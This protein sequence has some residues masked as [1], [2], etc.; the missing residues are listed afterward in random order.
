M[1]LTPSQ[2]E[3][4]EDADAESRLMELGL[5]PPRSV[6][7]ALQDGASSARAAMTA[8]HPASYPG[9]K[10]WGETTAALAL[11]FQ[12][13]GWE[14]EAFRNVDMVTH[15]G[16]GTAIIVTAGCSS[17]GLPAFVPEVRYER[18]DVTSAMVN[19]EF[20]DLWD[21]ATGRPDWTV[22]FLLHHLDRGEPLVPAEL[23]RPGSVAGG[24]VQS[25]AERIVIPAFDDGR[26]SRVGEAPEWTPSTGEDL[27]FGVT[28]RTAE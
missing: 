26:P 19:G 18:G 21:A 20:D 27:D 5:D 8:A 11:L 23:S 10:M 6:R 14:H 2:D 25:W 22:W 9:T 17:T 24:T 3:P 15:R 13:G 12:N 7:Q 16:R 1:Q 28:L 4:L